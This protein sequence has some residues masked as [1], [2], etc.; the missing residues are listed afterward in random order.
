ML[1]RL[2]RDGA[3][4]VV[5]VGLRAELTA[6][7]TDLHRP[8]QLA[9]AGAVSSG[10]STLINAILGRPVAPV[11]AG[12]CTRLVTWFEHGAEDGLVLVETHAGTVHRTWL[13]SD[14]VPERLPVPAAAVRRLRVQLTQ[15]WLRA[16]TVVDTPGLD[17]VTADTEQ[18]TRALLFGEQPAD[19]AQAMIYVFR[20]VLKFDADTLAEFH[21]LAGVC[22]MT[23]VHT[24]AVLSQI[25]RL[26]AADPWPAARRLTA[27][28]EAGLRRQVLDVC[29]VAGLLAETARGALL[30]DAELTAA[31]VLAALPEVDLSDALLDMAEF[32]AEDG[33]P[34]A[35][36]AIPVAVRRRLV[37]RLHRYGIR[38][39]AAHLRSHPDTDAGQLHAHLAEVSGFGLPG[40][41]P[42]PGRATVGQAI[43]RFI[44]YSDRY[45]A[46]AAMGRIGRLSRRPVAPADQQVMGELTDAVAADRPLAS[47]LGELRLLAALAAVGRGQL[48]LDDELIAELTSLVRGT[49]AASR[50]GLPPET[51]PEEIACAARAASLRWRR[52]GTI[53]GATAGGYRARDVLAAVEELAV[54][55]TDSS[56]AGLVP[57]TDRPDIELLLDAPGLDERDRASVR[58]LLGARDAAEALGMATGSPPAAL[59]AAAIELVGRLRVLMGR[60]LPGRHRRGLRAGADVVESILLGMGEPS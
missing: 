17:T 26:D 14:R 42:Q 53:A 35:V 37:A 11:D 32:G 7:A 31:R 22:G 21:A 56:G 50:L 4:R 9:V 28:A 58:A 39:A 5:D 41:P 40:A 59:R 48:R 43:E 16:V 1:D 34:A 20:Q 60:P 24:S 57:D 38:A 33:A 47:G 13:E 54:P 44:R 6:I 52:V 15:P 45:Q 49:D 18:A 55:A 29:P 25:D 30:G 51:G 3:R 10:K 46:L 8:L 19:H 27:R 36:A 2:C 23:A 12:E